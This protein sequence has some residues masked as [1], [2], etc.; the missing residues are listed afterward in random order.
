M[1]SQFLNMVR[2]QRRQPS[3][4]QITA[5]FVMKSLGV[6]AMGTAA[7]Y[8]W[9][10]QSEL[11]SNTLM[12]VS[13]T[14]ILV[15][16][17]PVLTSFLIPW[18]PGGMLLQEINAKTWGFLVVI[19]ASCF[20][21][22][23]S[24]DL[25]YSWWA[26]QPVVADTDLVVQQVL[27]GIIGFIVIPALLFTPVTADELVEKVAQAHTVKKYKMHAQTEIAALQADLYRM[28]YL[29]IH[30]S[31]VLTPEESQE[32]AHLRARMIEGMDEELQR[33]S[34]HIKD[35]TGATLDA[36]LLTDNEQVLEYLNYIEKAIALPDQEQR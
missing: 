3:P 28:R 35:V 25:Q 30:K 4:M 2:N 17:P 11:T 34:H 9:G 7:I 13:F 10:V 33:L 5:S 15:L 20:L 23:Y 26:A 36:P 12:A 31:T 22:Y 27:V 29:A 6:I 19:A 8:W 1:S 16:A 14:I 24:Y 32:L 21:L 18:S